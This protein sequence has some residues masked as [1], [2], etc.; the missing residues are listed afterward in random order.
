MKKQVENTI[1]FT[2]MYPKEPKF[3][4]TCLD[5]ASEKQ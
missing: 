3:Y 5:M 1:L 2:A 4:M